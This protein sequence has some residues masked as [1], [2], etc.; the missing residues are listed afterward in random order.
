MEIERYNVYKV[1]RKSARRILIDKGL[2]KEEAMKLVQSYPDSSKSMVV[3][4]KM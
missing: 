2:T 3:F 1:F 4:T